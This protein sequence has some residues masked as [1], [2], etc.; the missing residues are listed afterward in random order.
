[1]ALTKTM[2]EGAPWK[3]ILRFSLP[4]LAGSF[5]QQFYNTVDAIIVGKYAG[6]DALSAVGTTTSFAFLFLAL[7]IG[8]SSGNGVVVA[9]YFGAGDDKNVRANGAAGVVFLMVLG[10]ISAVL[11][12]ATARP[13]Y[14]NWLNVDGSILGLTVTYFRWYSLGLIFQFGY[15]I[16]S[17]ILRALGDSAATLYFLL[18]SS[19]LNIGLDLLFVAVFR[20]SVTGAAVATD[21]SQ[22]MSFIAA[23]LYTRR[24]YPVFRFGMGDLKWDPSRI[25]ATVKV[26]LPISLQLIFVSLGF[27][28]IQRAVNEFGKTMTAAFTV[29]QRV[30]TY[31]NFPCHAFQTTLATYTGQ[32]IGAGKIRRVKAG[33]KQAVALSLLLTLCISVSVWVFADKITA[34]FS[35][36]ERAADYSLSFL[37][38]VAVINILLASY[39]PLFGVF[40]GA[41]HSGFP[42]LVSVSALGA[43]VLATYLFRYSPFLGHTVIWWNGIFGF[44]LGFIMAWSYYLS[45]RWRKN[46]SLT[47]AGQ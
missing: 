32:N 11:G 27:T 14:A 28:F 25:K 22:L 20:W 33:A 15:N 26:G 24:K 47:G 44:G 9:Q 43:R 19:L 29:G 34:L 7:A 37:R 17:S 5:L 10:V 41:N 46:S 40:Q 2:T 18:I 4:V 30:E 42:T 8:F 31:L 3:H 45:G 1:M 13:A 16:F 6:E 21:I 39:I 35:V 38:T 36:S 23:Y 12:I